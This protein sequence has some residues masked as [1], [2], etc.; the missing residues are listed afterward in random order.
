MAYSASSIALRSRLVPRP[1]EIQLLTLN[2]HLFLD[3]YQA[4]LL[5]SAAIKG[6]ISGYG[7]PLSPV[8]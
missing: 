2:H 3:K 4:M 1:S 6:I 5:Y 8:L 7:C